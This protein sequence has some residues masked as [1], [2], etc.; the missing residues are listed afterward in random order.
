MVLPCFLERIKVLNHHSCHIEN[1]SI[2]GRFDPRFIH[3]PV[4]VTAKN[5][6]R[7]IAHLSS[8]SPR[9]SKLEHLK[10]IQSRFGVVRG[11]PGRSKGLAGGADRAGASYNRDHRFV[12]RQQRLRLASGVKG[13][14]VEGTARS[15]SRASNLPVASAGC[16]C[17][18]ENG[19][20]QST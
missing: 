5:P 3:D 13:I 16:D 2:T 11:S 17:R 4:A 9:P 15:G 8:C 12:S 19:S 6:F 7:M 14:P 18:S 20:F 10:D 1:V